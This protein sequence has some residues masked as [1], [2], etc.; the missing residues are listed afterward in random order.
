MKRKQQQQQQKQPRCVVKDVEDIERQ[1]FTSNWLTSLRKVDTLPIKR[2]GKVIRVTKDEV[3]D[4]DRSDDDGGRSDDDDAVEPADDDRD[5]K[6]TARKSKAHKSSSSTEG[7]LVSSSSSEKQKQK[8]HTPM[9]FVHR[10]A[11]EVSMMQCGVSEICNCIIADPEKS[12][13]K[14]SRVTDDD[15]D[16]ND[17]GDDD[18]EPTTSNTSNS[19]H[20]MADLF[21]M[22]RSNDAQLFE[23]A[24]LSALI[25][26]KDICPGYRIRS[27]AEY[28]KDVMLKKDTKQL[29]DYELSL[30]G[31]YQKY[32]KLLNDKVVFG[33]GNCRKDIDMWGL[34]AKIGL[35]ALRCQCEL[36]RSLSHFNFSSVLIGNIVTRSIQPNQDVSSLCCNTIIDLFKNDSIGELSYEVVKSVAKVLALCKYSSSTEQIIQCLSHAKLTVHSD[37]SRDVHRK[38][39]SQRKK[40][41][42]NSDDVEV[43]L[44]EAT[45]TTDKTIKMRFQADCLHEIS[46]IYFRIMKMKVG[47][48]LLPVAVDGLSR[49]SHLINIDT[50]QDLMTLLK[51][52]LEQH[53]PVLP[54]IQI[55]V[56]HCALKTLSGP[57][58]ELKLDSDVYLYKLQSVIRDLPCTFCRWDVILEC[59]ELC[60]L[61]KREERMNIVLSFVRLL[62]LNAVHLS[63]SCS[64]VVYA[65]IHAILTRYP[66]VRNDLLAI[67]PSVP[68][69][70]KALIKGRMSASTD[71][72]TVQHHHHHNYQTTK[73][74]D[75]DDYVED[76]AMKALRVDAIGDTHT[77]DNVNWEYQED[78]LGDGSWVLPLQRLHIDRRYGGL[79]NTLTSS[80]LLPIPLRISDLA[81]DSSDII[82]RNINHAIEMIPKNITISSKSSK[83]Q[84]TDDRFNGSKDRKRRRHNKQEAVVAEL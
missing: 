21:T 5:K 15:D 66:R 47:F 53:P 60:F 39:K 83:K 7:A 14:R 56:L 57:G 41:K 58:L 61:K 27:S 42:R 82:M 18:D 10:S 19:I 25:V 63:D 4:E 65:M 48:T 45:A 70:T 67:K 69:S 54:T 20:N 34:D 62:V 33:L 49:I 24:M 17:R 12:M 23:M 44:L 2:N 28:D 51:G 43:G 8:Q 9:M 36:L 32:I 52:I 1:S 46:L 84:G 80:D 50:V 78:K 71:T 29:R 74:F 3:E 22:L 79:V 26:F 16:D 37:D 73:L 81:V 72:A 6:G 68:V 55:H 75:E 11:H 40:R 64:P 76:L 31:A 77:I 35:S 38:A 30:L 59:L 13:K